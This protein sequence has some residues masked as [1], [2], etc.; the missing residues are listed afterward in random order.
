MYFFM[1]NRRLYQEPNG[2]VYQ[3]TVIKPS[4]QLQGQGKKGGAVFFRQ[5]S[6]FLFIK[7]S[8]GS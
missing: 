7:R 2:L 4:C 5:S 1:F 6:S 8:G 3:D